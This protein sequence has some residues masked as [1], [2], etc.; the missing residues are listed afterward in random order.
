[1][2]YVIR[3]KINFIIKEF[4]NVLYKGGV[5]LKEIIN[6][7]L[8]FMYI[9]VYVF[10]IILYNIGC[11]SWYGYEFDVLIVVIFFFF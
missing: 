10:F 6:L 2:M 1:M 8:F 11:I 5:L 4:L 9:F 3:K 7:I